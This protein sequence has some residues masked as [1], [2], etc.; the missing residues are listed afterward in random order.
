[1]I[2]N[3]S[4]P[5]TNLRQQIALAPIIRQNI[6]PIPLQAALAINTPLQKGN[7]QSDIF[8]GNFIAAFDIDRIQS[9]Q[10]HNAKNQIHFIFIARLVIYPSGHV[11]KKTGFKQIRNTLLHFFRQCGRLKSLAIP[12][13]D[14]AQY[15][16]FIHIHQPFC[17]DMA[18]RCR[19]RKFFGNIQKLRHGES[20]QN[21]QK[22]D[23]AKEQVDNT[24]FEDG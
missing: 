19:R 17:T 1:M 20:N 5:K 16:A 8:F 14:P 7:F 9:G 15:G 23:Y 24:Y 18:N 22:N 2:R 12:N 13:T 6:L 3:R 21:K 10:F 4:F 11:V